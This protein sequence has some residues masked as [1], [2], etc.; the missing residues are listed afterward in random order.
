MTFE[1]AILQREQ[2]M[3]HCPA[4]SGTR[5]RNVSGPYRVGPTALRT[6]GGRAAMRRRHGLDPVVLAILPSPLIKR[7]ISLL[8]EPFQSFSRVNPPSSVRVTLS[9]KTS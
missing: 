5:G 4:C 8:M 7:F 1:T 9:L 6:E 3:I 2:R